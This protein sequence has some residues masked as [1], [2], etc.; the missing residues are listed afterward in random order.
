MPLCGLNEI[1]G[2]VGPIELRSSGWRWLEGGLMRG[3]VGCRIEVSEEA[4]RGEI[5]DVF[6]ELCTYVIQPIAEKAPTASTD[7]VLRYIGRGL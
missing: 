6:E 7:D 5:S 1:V 3:A 4:C 2:L